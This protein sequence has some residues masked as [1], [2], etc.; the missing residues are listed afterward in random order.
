[1]VA[2]S[3]NHC[4]K[5][6]A[7][8]HFLRIL[9]KCYRQQYENF[10]RYITMILWLIY[11]GINVK[12]PIFLSDFNQIWILSTDFHEN[13]DKKFRGNLCRGSRAD[14]HGQTDRY[15]TKLMGAFRD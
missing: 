8:M 12:F 2:R 14:T 7:A 6:K 4:C 3:R 15:L 5:V 11:L 1:M 13:P 10:E 9:S